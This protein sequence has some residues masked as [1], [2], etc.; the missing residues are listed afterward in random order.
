MLSLLNDTSLISFSEETNEILDVFELSCEESNIHTIEP[1]NT[2]VTIIQ[3]FLDLFNNN[4]DNKKLLL[5]KELHNSFYIKSS[6]DVYVEPPSV[7]VYKEFIS[8]TKNREYLSL[9]DD[10]F[11]VFDQMTAINKGLSS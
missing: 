9:V 6:S 7:N 2:S 4:N 3:N 10:L 11:N 5:V 1:K 8:I